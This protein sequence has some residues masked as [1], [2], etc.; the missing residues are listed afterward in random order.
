MKPYIGHAALIAMMFGLFAVGA[1]AAEGDADDYADLRRYA[2]VIAAKMPGNWWRNNEA[3]KTDVLPYG[4]YDGLKYEGQRGLRLVLV[5]DRETVYGWEDKSGAFHQ[6]P[7][8]I[9]KEAITLWI[10][11]GEYPW[12][13]QSWKRFFVMKSQ[14]PIKEVYLGK[15]V[16]VYGEESGYW[17][18]DARVRYKEI[19]ANEDRKRFV[20]K[21]KDK[22]LSWTTWREDIVKILQEAEKEA[23]QQAWQSSPDASVNG[24]ASGLFGEH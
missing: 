13:R 6:E 24:A 11:P 17:P 4:H 20:W 10:M 22:V 21:P 12:P 15:M 19:M 16:Q 14:V 9:L 18:L 7:T 5:G 1:A 8:L 23:E 3:T 2:G